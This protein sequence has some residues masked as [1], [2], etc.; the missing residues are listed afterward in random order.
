MHVHPIEIPTPFPVGPV[1]VY[2]FGGDPLTLVDAGPKT[3]DALAALETGFAR[4]GHRVED[5]R[6]IVLTHGHVDHA[7][8]ARTLVE[9]SGAEVY[10]HPADLPKVGDTAAYYRAMRRFLE[11][12]GV[13]EAPVQGLQERARIM[14][15]MRD[16][17]RDVRTLQ[18]GDE[19]EMGGRRFRVLHCPGHSIGHIC[20][21]D[22]KRMLVAGDV[23]LGDISPNP[24]IE[25][26]VSGARI[27]TLPQYLATLR[28]LQDLPMEVALPGHGGPIAAPAA[29]AAETVAHHQARKAEIA[30][31]L[32]NGPRT[33]ADLTLTLFGNL[34]ELNVVLAISEV[35][36][37]LDLLVMEG[38]AA[39]E[40]RNGI[41]HYARTA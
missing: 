20:L 31:L 32:R 30:A 19:I 39:V 40:T 1:N 16:P 3:G 36:G 11:S 26:D 10:I 27:P 35:V 34:D 17:L 15:R 4:A 21:H 5:V 38:A 24:L 8:L 23:L 29:R 13:P 7:G 6:R 41:L 12:A 33:L 37:H 25:F 22:G 14:Q 9:R 18:E 2:L 28:R